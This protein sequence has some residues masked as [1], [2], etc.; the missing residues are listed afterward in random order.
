MTLL[1]LEENSPEELFKDTFWPDQVKNAW[2]N[3]EARVNLNSIYELEDIQH[4]LTCKCCS[5]IPHESYTCPIKAE[6]L[7]KPQRGRPKQY[8]K[9]RRV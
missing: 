6:R 7:A 9:E 5:K 8:R 3:D 1:L 2:K 4:G